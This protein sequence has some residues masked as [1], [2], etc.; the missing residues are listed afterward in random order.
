MPLAW[1]VVDA[2]WGPA[3]D[4]LPPSYLP[5]LE[6]RRARIPFDAGHIDGLQRMQPGF[7]VIGDSMGGRIQP[8]RLTQL[9]DEFVAPLLRNATGSAFWYLAFKNYVVQSGIQ[10]RYVVVF[11][12]DTNLTDPLWRGTGFYRE[13]LDY[14]AMDA[15]PA[16]DAVMAA[17]ST[18]PWHQ[19]HRL[20]AEIYGTDRARDSLEP[21][22]TRWLAR[23]V[24]GSSNRTRLLEDANA[25]FALEGLR[26][27]PEADMAAVADREADFDAHVESSVL[28]LFLDLAREHHLHLVFVRVLRRTEDGRVRA[29]SPALTAYVRDLREYVEAGGATFFDD[30]DDPEMATIRYDDGDHIA[31]E[32]RVRYTEYFWA[33]L[34][35]L[36][37]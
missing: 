16:L 22:L 24:A 4:D 2:A 17:R 6:A 18:G 35:R 26:P 27:I 15:E 36:A 21:A 11:F 10:P 3:P 37:R 32:D 13:T 30:R 31:R 23:V 33:R 5:S 25:R 29:E 9:S 1:R 20:A 34:Q 28:P 12:R 8:E 7:V 19:A 14:A